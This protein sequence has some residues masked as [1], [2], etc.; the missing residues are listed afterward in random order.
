MKRSLFFL[1]FLSFAFCASANNDS[2]LIRQLLHDLDALQLKVDD[3]E[4]YAGMWPGTRKGGG[5]PHNLQPDNNIFFT[6]LSAFTLTNML[7]YLEGENKIT[8][9]KIIENATK[10]YPHFQNELGKPFYNFWPTNAPIMPHSV[11]F[12]YLTSV[13][14][15]GEDADDTVMILMS[16][17]NNDSNN[18]EVKQRMIEV[19]NLSIKKI[20][21][22]FPDYRDLP[23][24]STWLGYKMPPDFDFGVQ[25]NILYFMYQKQLF[26]SKQDTA[27]LQLIVDIAKTRKYM[28]RPAYIS[29]YYVTS[30][31]ELYHLTRLM[32]AFS[33]P[34]LDALKP[35]IIADIHTLLESSKNLMDQII[36]RTSLLRLQ[37]KAPPL[38]IY[39]VSDFEESNQQDYIYFQARPA[40][41]YPTPFKQIFLHLPYIN[42]YF[43]CPAYNKTLWLEYLVEKGKS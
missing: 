22:T 39:A 7:P 21:S 19:S 30:A 20:N 12:K 40:F 5:I 4:F 37:A 18:A 10:A 34:E 11:F 9:Q 35:Q 26:N 33:I 29:S 16:A 3:D 38:E 32:A 2:L 36:L 28:L 14:Y 24:Y 17:E 43:Y 6:A 23:A 31:I 8:G 27:T 1:L 41:W 25:C 42:S 15:Q 13:F